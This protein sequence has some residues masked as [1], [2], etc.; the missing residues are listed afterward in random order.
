MAII[1]TIRFKALDK[2]NALW[3]LDLCLHCQTINE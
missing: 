3:E 1:H 2:F